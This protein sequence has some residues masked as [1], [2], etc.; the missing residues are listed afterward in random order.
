[1]TNEIIVLDPE[2]THGPAFSALT[3][4]QQKFVVASL[5]LGGA[6]NA[7]AARC[8][9]YSTEQ[10][11]QRGWELMRMQHVIAA[12]KEEA[13]L[14]MQGGAILASSAL[15]AIVTNPL[16]KE[17]FK[18]CVELLNRSGLQFIQKHEVVHT[19][20]RTAAEL[21]AYIKQTAPRL[22]GVAQETIDAQFEEVDQDLAAMLGEADGD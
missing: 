17:H 14:R 6:N 1:M 16:H 9:G 11:R 4:K 10:A 21:V 8:A 12:M 7:E 20:N 13:E 22:L 15:L 2:G 18:A 3:E 5:M 19:D